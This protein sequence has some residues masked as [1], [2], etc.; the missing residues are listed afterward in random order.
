MWNDHD[1]DI[2]PED[3]HDFELK[4]DPPVFSRDCKFCGKPIILKG[5]FA[6][7]YKPYDPGTDT[8]HQCDFDD[9]FPLEN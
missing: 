5:F 3:L 6:G 8:I 1:W 4:R 2:W 7:A 9:E